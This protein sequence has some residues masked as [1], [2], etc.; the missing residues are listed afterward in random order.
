MLSV[1]GG[2]KKGPGAYF[3]KNINVRLKNTVL[4]DDRFVTCFVILGFKT[5]S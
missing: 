1:A 4:N 5:S 2:T 3:C